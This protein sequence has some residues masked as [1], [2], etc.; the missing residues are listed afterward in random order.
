M[1]KNVRIPAGYQ[2]NCNT[3]KATVKP[4][5]LITNSVILLSLLT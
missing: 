3:C 5:E 4:N 1:A 2:M